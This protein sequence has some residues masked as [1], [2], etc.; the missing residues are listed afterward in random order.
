MFVSPSSLARSSA[1]GAPGVGYL[2]KRLFFLGSEAVRPTW[3]QAVD[4]PWP[5][6]AGPPWLKAAGPPWPQAEGL[7]WPIVVGPPWPKAVGPPWSKAVGILAK[8]LPNALIFAHGSKRH[9]GVKPN[10]F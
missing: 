10:A 4:P 7:L 6:V 8:A 3:P 9:R 5:M 2:S 1:E